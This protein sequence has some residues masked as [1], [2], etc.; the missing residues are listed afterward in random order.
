MCVYA[1]NLFSICRTS[2]QLENSILG[3]TSPFVLFCKDD[4]LKLCGNFRFC[5]AVEFRFVV[6]FGVISM[7]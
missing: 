5:N 4:K 6:N 2:A 7:L 1:R 3:S